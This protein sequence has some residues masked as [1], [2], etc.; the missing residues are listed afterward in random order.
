MRIYGPHIKHM[1][2][3]LKINSV[4]GKPYIYNDTL[5]LGDDA[6]KGL[7]TKI[8]A[9]QVAQ[10]REAGVSYIECNAFRARSNPSWV[11]YKVWPKLGYDGDIP[12]AV[13]GDRWREIEPKLAAAGFKEPYQVSH[14]YKIE[15][16]QEWWEEHGEAFDAKFDL[17]DDS[18]SM[19]VLSAYLAEKAKQDNTTPEEWLSKMAAKKPDPKEPDSKKPDDKKKKDQHEN[20]DLDAADHKALDAVWKKFRK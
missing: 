9:N 7:G 14:L 12:G 10:A 11:G 2:R 5:M 3:E 19:K 13:N 6:P 8:F 1:V 17:S 4:N 15:G 18:H 20:V 16:G